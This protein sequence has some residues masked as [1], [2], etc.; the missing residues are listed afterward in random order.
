MQTQTAIFTLKHSLAS[1]VHCTHT[2]YSVLSCVS[3]A[4]KG[5]RA[6]VRHGRQGRQAEH[7]AQTQTLLN[8]LPIAFTRPAS[9]QTSPSLSLANTLHVLPHPAAAAPLACDHAQVRGSGAESVGALADPPAA[10]TLPPLCLAAP[11]FA[12]AAE[13]GGG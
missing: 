12:T 1:Y 6:P 2:L 7:R 10:P 11:V 3:G 13:T 5:Q 8:M 4:F 9:S